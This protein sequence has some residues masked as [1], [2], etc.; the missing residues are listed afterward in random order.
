MLHNKENREEEATHNERLPFELQ[1]QPPFLV[2][3]VRERH[4][5][6]EMNNWMSVHVLTLNDK[7]NPFQK[8]YYHI[9]HTTIMNLR[10]M[11]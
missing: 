1:T 7:G 5:R 10:P 6:V 9:V 11:I 4:V 2:N 3:V 8:L